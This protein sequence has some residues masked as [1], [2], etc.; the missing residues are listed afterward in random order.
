MSF[1]VFFAEVHWYCLSI[2]EF[3]EFA[4]G[5]TFLFPLLSEVITK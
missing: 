1:A 5:F 4:G 2:T 3:R